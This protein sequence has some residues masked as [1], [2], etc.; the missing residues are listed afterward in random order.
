MKKKPFYASKL[1]IIGPLVPLF[2]FTAVGF[3]LLTLYIGKENELRFQQEL[4]NL[5]HTGPRIMPLIIAANDEKK[6]D[7]FTDAFST[8]GIIRTTIIDKSGVVQ[9]DS[10]LS[11]FEIRTQEN[12]KSRPE[13]E[14]AHKSGMGIS[15]RFSSVM[16]AEMLFV[17]VYFKNDMGEG[18]FR[19]AAPM[20]EIRKVHILQQAFLAVTFL[21]ALIFLT[22][23]SLLISK[24]LMS[25]VQRNRDQLE[26]EVAA[27]NDEIQML[28]NLSTQLTACNS[29]DEAL[30]VTAAV[31][32]RILSDYGGMVGLIRSSRDKV[33]VVAKWNREFG[34]K[35]AFLPD[36]CWALRTGREYVSDLP[37]GKII[38]EHYGEKKGISICIPLLAQGDM[39][40]VMQFASTEINQI[41]PEQQQLAAAVA[42]STSLSLASLRSKEN[43]RQQAIRDP[44]TGLHNRRYL[45]EIME[46][47]LNR[48]L[49]HQ[50][51]M[52]V[53]MLD[54]DHFKQFNDQYGHD[55]GDFI[56]REL[57]RMAKKIIRDED[58]ACRYGGEEFVVLLPETDT[59]GARNVAERICNEMRHR[60]FSL[61]GLSLGPVTVSIGAA[62]FPA[63]GAQSD[64]L[65]KKADTA[66]YQAK[67]NGRDRVVIAG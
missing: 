41:M 56:L 39:L 40:G 49:R 29:V 24:Y 51:Q 36:E 31:T 32:A 60:Q 26:Q 34:G 20:S 59:N 9:G 28:Q 47:E 48:S 15:R 65:L 19:T 61:E 33:E 6:F 30:K 66:L 64:I 16:N 58:T 7:S 50:L 52:S 23:V 55:A 27:R 2:L 12:Q 10:K 1:M 13:I 53:L 3:V 67:Q 18:Y 37:S 63:N 4:I 38:C 44:L 42:E 11:W 8:E 57:G 5:A 43:L 25:A 62:T 22:V 35:G 54:V 21:L 45:M 46:H 17:A 14:A